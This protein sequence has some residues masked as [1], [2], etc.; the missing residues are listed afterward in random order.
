MN[1]SHGR[2]IGSYVAIT[3]EGHRGTRGESNRAA[4]ASAK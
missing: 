4:K 1:V 3:G 2:A